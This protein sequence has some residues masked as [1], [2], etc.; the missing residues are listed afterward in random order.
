MGWTGI[1]MPK[2]ASAKE[3]AE[4]LLEVFEQ[5]VYSHETKTTV[6]KHKLVGSVLYV[7]AETIKEN[8]E[9]FKWIGV[10][11]TK[12]DKKTDELWH[13][14]L[15]N[16]VG[17]AAYDCPL[18]WFDEVPVYNQFDADWRENCKAIKEGKKA[19]TSLFKSLKY[20]DRVRFS[21]IY[22]GTSEWYYA[23]GSGLFQRKPGA[24][25]VKLIGWKKHIQEI[26]TD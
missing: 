25:P 3:R 23:G 4:K 11:C 9:P 19:K 6:H 13:K 14:L 22:D 15:D 21:T 2:P 26:I 17:P 20:G 8:G 16:S 7:L 12:W 1:Y 5:E 10:L 18:S 24:A